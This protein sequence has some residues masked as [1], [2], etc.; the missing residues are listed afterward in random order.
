MTSAANMIGA[1]LAMRKADIYPPAIASRRLAFFDRFDD[2]LDLGLDR[3]HFRCVWIWNKAA[4]HGDALDQ[5]GY[6][7][8]Q[9]HGEADHDQR[10]RWPLRE[11]TGITRLFVDLERTLEERHAGD[12]HD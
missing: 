2:V 7:L 3:V 9:Q 8:H 4:H 1:I 11:A 12:Q 10:L 6:S 5:L